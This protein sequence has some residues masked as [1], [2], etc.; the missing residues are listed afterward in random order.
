MFV[1]SQIFSVSENVHV[2][3]IVLRTLKNHVFKIYIHFYEKYSFFSKKF[4]I[5]KMTK[6]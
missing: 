3:Q 6:K 5:E 2:S 4:E 1:V